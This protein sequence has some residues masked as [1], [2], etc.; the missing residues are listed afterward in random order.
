M[1]KKYCP[2]SILFYKKTLFVKAGISS[3]NLKRAI[4]VNLVGNGLKEP[5]SNPV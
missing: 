2:N 3:K 1:V 5:N 4:V